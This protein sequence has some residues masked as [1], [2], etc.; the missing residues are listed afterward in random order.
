[1]RLATPSDLDRITYWTLAFQDEALSGGDMVETR[2]VSRHK[3][4]DQDIYLW[5]DGHPVSMASRSRPTSRGICLSLVYTPPEWRGRGYAT[6]CVA[7]LSQLL[8][9]SGREFC[10]LFTDLAN[11]TSNHIYQTIGYAPVCDFSEYIFGSEQR[12]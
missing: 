7:G 9:D 12:L 5:E 10:V 6:A 3:I 1:L 8:L 11:P 4:N 2:E